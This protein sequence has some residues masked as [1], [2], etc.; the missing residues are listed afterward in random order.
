MTW[1][2]LGWI[3]LSV[4][5]FIG[6]ITVVVLALTYAE[7]KLIARVQQRMGPMRTGPF[8]LLQPV[9]DAIK[10]LAKEDLTPG[11]S[12]KATFWIAP[13]VVFV[14]AFVAW[15]TIPFTRDIAIR[16]LEFGILFIIA[17]S[18]VSVAGLLMAGFGSF[19]KYAALGGLRAAAQL[20]SYE[21]PLVV[22]VLG[23]VMIAGSMDLRVIVAEQDTVWYIALQPVAFLLFIIAGLAEVMRPPFDIPV[24]ES[25]LAGG[26]FIEYSGIHWSMFSLAEYANT[27]AVAVLAALLFLGGW[28]GP[29]PESGWAQDV[30]QALWLTVKV[31]AML[32]AMFWLRTSIPR[33]RIDQLMA[34]AWKGM[35]PVAFLN[36]LL[37]AFYLYYGWPAWTVSAMSFGV[38]GGMFALYYRRRSARVGMPETAR[39]RVEKGRVVG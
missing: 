20:M 1:T 23:V 18:G 14:P 26:P 15:V 10:L 13:V 27:F 35:L 32:G 36:V 6:F 12:D 29:A 4:A 25:E 30:V 28:G 5:L 39:V 31:S 16:N 3:V 8:G 2:E 38:L 7:R 19:N 33:L 37:T 9:A 21:L 24:A 34:V 22:G 17:V 11:R